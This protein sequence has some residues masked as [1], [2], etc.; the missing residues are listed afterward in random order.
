MALVN[1]KEFSEYEKN[2]VMDMIEKGDLFLEK[3]LKYKCSMGN[4]I[5][6]IALKTREGIL[7]DISAFDCNAGHRG[8]I[9]PDMVT[10]TCNVKLKKILNGGLVMK[11]EYIPATYCEVKSLIEEIPKDSIKH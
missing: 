1:G 6:Y 7:V 10:P 4:E 3:G 5:E 8:S 9:L 11:K 2:E